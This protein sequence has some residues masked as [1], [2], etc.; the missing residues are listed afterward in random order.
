MEAGRVRQILIY[1]NVI[2]FDGIS[3]QIRSWLPLAPDLT[4]VRT[5]C[6]APKDEPAEARKRRIRQ[7]E[8]FY[9]ASGIATPHD[10][11]EFES[12]QLGYH[13]R[14]AQWQALRPRH[15]TPHNRCRFPCPR[16][17]NEPAASATSFG[18]ETLYHGEYRHWLKML[19]E[20][21]RQDLEREEQNHAA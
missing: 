12:C 10:L 7:Y 11:T 5:Y 15:G 14:N 17:G 16:I 1:P 3:T 4:E 9:S 6:I 18:D 13:G 8:D 21:L 19:T 20:G 2:L